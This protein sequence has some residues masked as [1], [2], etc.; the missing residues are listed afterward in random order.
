[1]TQRLPDI[2]IV[3]D[4]HRPGG[5]PDLVARYRYKSGQGTWV[6]PQKGNAVKVT[7]FAGNREM[8]AAEYLALGR[9]EPLDGRFREHHEICCTICTNR[10]K[11]RRDGL[12]HAFRECVA[13]GRSLITL[14]VL[15]DR[16]ERV[17]K[18]LR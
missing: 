8:G 3:C 11:A 17:V 15:R 6:P 16:Y 10:L 13:D 7:Y 5:P 18:L 2:V 1:M 14:D 4:R 9:G 12:V